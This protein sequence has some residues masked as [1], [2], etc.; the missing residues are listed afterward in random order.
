VTQLCPKS[1]TRL[2]PT[3]L[4]AGLLL[5]AA[6]NA[7]VPT[8]QKSF[9]PST[10]G[11]SS[12]STLVFT[13]TN[14]S[15]TPAPSLAFTDSLPAG[16]TVADPAVTSNSCGGTV[17]ADEGDTSISFGGGSLGG[18]SSCSLL[19]N[20]TGSAAGTYSNVT[21]DLTSSAGNSGTASADLTVAIDRP[22]FTKSFSPNPA[23]FNGR[24]RLTLTIDNSLNADQIF[25]I[26]F[27]DT[28]PAGM[29]VAGP[30]NLSNTCG[31]T[32]TASGSQVSLASG[33]GTIIAS[34]A[35]CTVGVDVIAGSVGSLQNL[36]GDLTV[37]SFPTFQSRPGGKAGDTLDVFAERLSL[38]KTFVNDPSAP[39][40]A[41]DLRFDLINLDRRNEVTA[42]E[43]TD[44]LDAT[45]SGLVAVS[46]PSNPCGS[47]SVI[48]GTGVL[49]LT[50][51]NLPA[52]GSC[53]FTVGLEV[54][55][56]ATSG[57][58]TNTTSSVLGDSAG[59][60]VSGPPASDVLVVDAGSLGLTKTFLDN[61]VGAGATTTLEF[62]LSNDGSNA[63]SAIAFFDEFPAELPTA[64]AVPRISHGT[65]SSS[66]S[67]TTNSVGTLNLE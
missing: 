35:S 58:Y 20:V 3:A 46:L 36:T 30:S 60:T 21:G 39:G 6:A 63:A 22:G 9:S 59:S 44:D 8:V 16:L 42:I 4:F 57:S 62:T 27:S 67:P 52:E 45:L 43:F 40:G 37:F 26:R 65:C 29:A 64:S 61:P 17:T 7:Q 53:S 1:F 23:T 38:T 15:G 2:L 11:P 10:I 32:A 51:G 28:L 14:P 55:A 50:G 24:V 54:P 12:I 25:N 33:T 49:S 18:S 56:S 66:C 5:T 19:V 31:G 48:S 47:G 41:V 34:G 13:I